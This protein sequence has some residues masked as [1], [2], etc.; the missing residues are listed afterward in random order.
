M[1]QVGYEP[2]IPVFERTKTVHA[3]D[4]VAFF[5]NG[6]YYLMIHRFIHLQH[7]TQALTSRQSVKQK[8]LVF[9]TVKV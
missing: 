2:T 3:L 1:L 6:R 4:R 5:H 8:R 7:R 9:K